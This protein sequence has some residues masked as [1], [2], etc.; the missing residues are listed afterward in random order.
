MVYDYRL[1]LMCGSVI[2]CDYHLVMV[3]DYRPVMVCDSRH[4]MLCELALLT[5]EFAYIYFL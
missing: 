3:C 4:D 1:V 5:Q 2:V